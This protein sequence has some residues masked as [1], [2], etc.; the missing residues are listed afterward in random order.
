M[1]IFSFFG[2]SSSGKTTIIANIISELSGSM[3]IGYI[4]NIPHD[5][6]SLDT[7]YKDTWKMENA[8][9]YRIYGLAPSRTYSMVRK[10][11]SPVEIIEKENDVDIFIIEGFRAFNKSIKFLAI[12]GDMPYI[13]KESI[14]NILDNYKGNSM[15]YMSDNFY[16]PLF[17][18][19]STDVEQPM[20]KYRKNGKGS[21]RKFMD[22]YSVSYLEG[23]QEKLK[24]I[25]TEKDLIEARKNLRCL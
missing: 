7:E 3:K 14:E 2:S 21:I 10:E 6:I 8:G 22:E 11:T 16:Q 20:L 4:K 18:I 19:Y 25:N 23:D 1:K 9:A 12:G 5:N 24:S 15:A 13:D 17:A